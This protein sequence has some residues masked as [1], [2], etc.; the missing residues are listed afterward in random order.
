[1]THKFVEG[2][3]FVLLPET[4]EDDPEQKFNKIQILLW[5]YRD[6]VVRVGSLRFSQTPNEDGSVNV[7]FDWEPVSLPDGLKEETLRED[8]EFNVVL[9][10]TLMTLLEMQLDEQEPNGESADRDTNPKGA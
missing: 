6:I 2:L 10:E 4:T 1:M 5:P 9:G 8:R 3:D 7:N